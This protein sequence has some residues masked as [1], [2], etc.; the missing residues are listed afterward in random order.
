MN[1]SNGSG[2]SSTNVSLS[3]GP[4]N[5]V[6]ALFVG[7]LMLATL[8]GNFLVWASFITFRELR[9]K[10]NYFIISLAVADIMVALLAMPFWF[11]LQLEPDLKNYTM[12]D[13]RS[14]QFWSCI[15][16]LC[17]TASIMNLLAVSADRHL[18]ITAPY[19]YHEFLTSLRAIFIICF[20]W[21]YAIT[22]SLLNLAKG[23]IPDKGYHYLVSTT[24]LILPLA[25]MVIMYA[26]IYMVA[27]RQARIIN[28]HQNYKTD[29]KAAKTIAVVIGAFV[30]CWLPFF[31]TII[32]YAVDSNFI[33]DPHFKVLRAIKW[34]EYLNSCLNPIIY[35]CLNRTYRGAFIRLFKRWRKSSMR[36]FFSNY[37]ETTEDDNFNTTLTRTT[38]KSSMLEKAGE[39]SC[40]NQLNH[41][42]E[43]GNIKTELIASNGNGVHKQT[44]V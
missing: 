19:K 28:L 43:N 13:S 24:S 21:V 32:G 33:N 34:M 37:A 44:Q 26:R 6:G 22:I 39:D 27:R 25:A 23:I 12:L 2:N 16:I 40:N 35:C 41:V 18:A 17:G 5:I 8:F 36:L 30:V 1:S 15:D 42:N 38:Q 11:I 4:E 20:V 10:C 3:L 31:V 14:M 29:I 9:T 7:L